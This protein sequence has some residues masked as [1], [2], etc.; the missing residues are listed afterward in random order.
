MLPTL[1]LAHYHSPLY[2]PPPHICLEHL[3]G[4]V[5][6]QKCDDGPL[7][8][9]PQWPTCLLYPAPCP[10]QFHSHLPT[11]LPSNSSNR[12]LLPMHTP[13]PTT[14][15]PSTYRQMAT[16]GHRP[17]IRRALVIGIEYRSAAKEMQLRAPHSDAKAWKQFII[18]ESSPLR[19]T[20]H[21]AH[22]CCES[23]DTYGYRDEDITLMLDEPGFPL[24]PT[25][26]QIVSCC[27]ISYTP[28]SLHC[29]TPRLAGSDR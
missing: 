7:H 23:L 28:L 29:L 15:R 16:P 8:L 4:N 12:I 20:L 17:S 1:R 26:E 24:Q 10:P 14:S 18:G 22:R 9:P 19:A 25:K 11:R 13:A 21:A 3:R 5:P 6:F 2:N 27:C